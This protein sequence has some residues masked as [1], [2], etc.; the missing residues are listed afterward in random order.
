MHKTFAQGE[1]KTE[2]KAGFIPWSSSTDM[3]RN[4]GWAKCDPV[5]GQCTGGAPA[6]AGVPMEA[7]ALYKARG[8]DKIVRLVEQ[9]PIPW[10]AI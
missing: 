6:P 10:R 5:T 8:I 1:V 3:D 4:K 2:Y 7:L 9:K